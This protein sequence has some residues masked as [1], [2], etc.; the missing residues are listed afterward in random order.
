[1]SSSKQTEQLILGT[2]QNIVAVVELNVTSENHINIYI[3][4]Y[5]THDVFVM[6]L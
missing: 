2:G 4:N 1:M 5:K 3:D 6:S